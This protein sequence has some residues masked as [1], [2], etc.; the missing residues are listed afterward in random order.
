[1][2]NNKRGNGYVPNGVVKSESHPICLDISLQRGGK[3]SSRN[4]VDEN[5]VV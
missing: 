4:I 2:I 5:G 1:M 3:I